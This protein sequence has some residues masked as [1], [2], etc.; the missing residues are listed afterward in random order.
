MNFRQ[1]SSLKLQIHEQ[2]AQIIN[3]NAK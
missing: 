2:Q 3:S 1:M